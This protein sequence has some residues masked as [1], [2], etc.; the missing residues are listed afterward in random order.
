MTLRL[1]RTD[2]WLWQFSARVKQRLTHAG[3]PAVT[4]D[5]TAF[6]P[7]SGGQPHDIGTLNG[8]AVADVVE[9]EDGDIIH[10]LDGELAGDDVQG[11]LDGA[12]RMDHMQQHSGQHVLSQAFVHTS[13]LDTI[14]VHI[15]ADDCTIDLPTARLTADALVRAEDKANQI[16]VQDLPLTVRELSDAEVAQLPLRKPP[17]VTGRIRIV[18]VQGFDWSACGGTHVSRSGQIGMIRVVRAEKRGDTTRIYF[19]CGGRALADYREV[20]ALTN[21]LVEQFR[22]SRAELL[23]AID[24]L[25]EEARATR[26]ELLDAQSRLLDYEAQELLRDAK[27]APALN[28]FRMI[29]RAL[30]GRDANALKFMAK[31]LTAE[32]GI[33]VLL[34]AH[35]DGKAYWCFAR[36]RDVALDMGALLRSALSAIDTNGARG[37]GSADFAQGS[38]AAPDSRTAQM[39]LDWAAAQLTQN[40]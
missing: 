15:G 32:P 30:D 16:V 37:G 25:R 40:S 28:G 8:V 14:A 21:A 35:S 34:A 5:Q 7:A 23:P 38:G 19:R 13:N 1:Y 33:A 18:E 9:R 31:R 10:V 20:S 4:L 24:R 6:Y 3:C 12:R 22:M 26:K 36:S 39:V 27:S 11:A 2:P 17:A 29:A